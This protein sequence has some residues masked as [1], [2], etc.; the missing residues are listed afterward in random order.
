MTNSWNKIKILFEKFKDLTSL[1]SATVVASAISA[2][3]WFYMASILG[4]EHYGE[5]SYFISISTLAS[6]VSLIG[7]GNALLVYPAKDVKIQP[8]VYFIAL[9]SSLITSSILFLIF[10]NI[11]ISLYVIGYVI[12]ALVGGDLLG[13]KFYKNYSK[14]LI[15]QKI[16][17]ILLA[18]G[19]YYIVGYQ[20]VILGISLSF[21][22]FSILMYRVF[23]KTKIDFSLVKSRFGFIINSYALDISRIFS[24]SIDRLIVAPLFGYSLLGNYQLGLQLFSALSILPIVVYQYILPHDAGGNPNKRLKRVTIIIS[25]IFAALSITLSPFVIPALFPKFTEAVSVIQIISVAI[26]PY[27]IIQ[28]YVSQFLGNTNSRVVLSASIVYLI[29]QITT[30]IPL[31]KIVGIGGIAIS[32]VLAQTAELVYL[33]IMDRFMQKKQLTK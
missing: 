19:L 9:I 28:M 7:F 26:I 14:I 10:Y 32:F 29:V 12:F 15:I 6:V 22:P 17:M 2:I 5:I 4:T 24:G 20:G 11:G 31:G 27:T 3:F 18:T 25:V 23:R 16:L 13:R 33:F 30:I 21:L 8:P 1:G